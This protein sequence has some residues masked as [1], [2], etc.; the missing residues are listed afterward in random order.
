[1]EILNTNFQLIY[2]MLILTVAILYI[3]LLK[4]NCINNTYTNKIS[5]FYVTSEEG[6]VSIVYSFRLSLLEHCL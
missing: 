5:C 6:L 1:M 4:P 2:M 3:N